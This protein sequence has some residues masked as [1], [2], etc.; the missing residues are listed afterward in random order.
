MRGTG[1][2]LDPV[3]QPSEQGSALRVGPD[4]G[5]VDI[6]PAFDAHGPDDAIPIATKDDVF[7]GKLGIPLRSTPALRHPSRALGFG[8]EAWAIAR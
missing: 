8:I 5:E 3:E 7:S 2:R 6:A 1:M 4:K